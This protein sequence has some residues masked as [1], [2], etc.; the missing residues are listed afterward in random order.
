MSTESQRER[1]DGEQKEEIALIVMECVFRWEADGIPAEQIKEM[2]GELTEHL[3]DALRNGRPVEVVVG[4]NVGAFADEWGAPYRPPNRW[5][6]QLTETAAY[7]FAG[8]PLLMVVQHLRYKSLDFPI[9][10]RKTGKQIL[11]ASWVAAFTELAVRARLRDEKPGTTLESPVWKDPVVSVVATTIPYLAMLGVNFLIKGGD[12]SAF[13]EWSW[14]S[15][16]IGAAIG[17][18]LLSKPWETIN[19]QSSRPRLGDLEREIDRRIGEHQA[20]GH[21]ESE[22]P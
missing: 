13:S 5:R 1:I 16:L 21:A 15:T 22:A 9:D 19:T 14:K 3:I 10:I 8:M 11:R 4:S 18:A 17:V 12:R 7:T 6:K 20:P 2:S